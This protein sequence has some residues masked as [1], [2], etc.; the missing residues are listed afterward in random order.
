[1]SNSLTQKGA[2]RLAKTRRQ[3]RRKRTTT[4]SE[5]RAKAAATKRQLNVLLAAEKARQEEAAIQMAKVTNMSVGAMRQRVSGVA[6]LRAR[7]KVNAYNAFTHCQSLT[8]NDGS[9]PTCRSSTLPNHTSTDLPEGQRVR[10]KE[11]H[12]IAHA[13]NGYHSVRKEDLDEMKE[14]LIKYREKTKTKAVAPVGGRVQHIRFA[15]DRVCEEVCC[16]TLV[17]EHD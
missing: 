1:M 4:N 16:R 15:C 8:I 13:H 10:L 17:L 14:V 6:L 11:L 9:C 3:C 12:A 7:R 5:A 2:A